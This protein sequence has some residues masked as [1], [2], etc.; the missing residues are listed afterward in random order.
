LK[1]EGPQR[2]FAAA[3]RFGLLSFALLEVVRR[4][5]KRVG[6]KFVVRLQH[7]EAILALF[8]EMDK[9]YAD[10]YVLIFVL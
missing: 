4:A 1:I 2:R 3:L 7:L 6:L 10:D 9:K 8:P 5:S